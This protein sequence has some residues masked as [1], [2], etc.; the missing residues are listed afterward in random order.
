MVKG[1][2]WFEEVLKGLKKYHPTYFY[3]DDT[4]PAL[5]ETVKKIND[6][7]NQESNPLAQ[8]II[9]AIKE[10]IK[11]FI[12]LY[13]L[14]YI[15]CAYE[16][17]WIDGEFDYK[18]VHEL[19][20]LIL[21]EKQRFQCKCGEIND[22]L[23]H[24]LFKHHN[25]IVNHL[26]TDKKDT[27]KEFF[28]SIIGSSENEQEVVP[29]PKQVPV[30]NQKLEKEAKRGQ[31]SLIGFLQDTPISNDK[32]TLPTKKESKKEENQR[33][34]QDESRLRGICEELRTEFLLDLEKED[35]YKFIPISVKNLLRKLPSDHPIVTGME[36]WID[37]SI[38]AFDLGLIW[39]KYSVSWWDG[40]FYYES[41]DKDQMEWHCGI[42]GEKSGN[43]EAF[44]SCT[45]CNQEIHDITAHVLNKHNQEIEKELDEE[46]LGL[47]KT[48]I[49]SMES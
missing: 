5:G 24:V 38:K 40:E 16:V 17:G 3:T 13:Y 19:E 29:Q 26:V 10:V 8:D 48:I 14:V 42:M 44:L 35:K 37:Y 12:E 25:D 46:E 28:L 33:I 18:A 32:K 34:K 1:V 39:Y 20:A 6:L 7:P 36:D 43:T 4:T 30:K 9:L 23:I 21:S 31:T 11:E 45:V 22:P 15:P 2:N 41:G 27:G 47:F 49:E